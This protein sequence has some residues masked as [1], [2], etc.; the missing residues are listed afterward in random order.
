LKYSCMFCKWSMVMLDGVPP[1][2]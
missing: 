2:K 1:L